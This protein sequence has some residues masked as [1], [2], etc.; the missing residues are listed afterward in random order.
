MANKVH[1]RI[2]SNPDI[3]LGK[4][5]IKGTRISVELILKKLS[6]GT[7]V[8]Q[9]LEAYPNLSEKDISAALDYASDVISN[10]TVANIDS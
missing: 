4:P 3:L 9:L 6:E 8:T 7:T 2:T 5:V 1:K 10:E